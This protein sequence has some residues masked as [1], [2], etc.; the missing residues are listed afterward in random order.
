MNKDKLNLNKLDNSDHTD[1]NEIEYD[2]LEELMVVN[3]ESESDEVDIEVEELEKELSEIEDVFGPNVFAERF[4]D[5]HVRVS[6]RRLR[7]YSGPGTNYV[8]LGTAKKND[9]FIIT[10]ES[11]GL[12]ALNWGKIKSDEMAWI[13]LDYCERI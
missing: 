5:Y 8:V 12:G 4:S 6:V 7:Y 3:P 11:T 10:E 9:E 1:K 13:P 2:D